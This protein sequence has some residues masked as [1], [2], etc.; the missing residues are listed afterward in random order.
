MPDVYVITNQL[1]HYWGKSKQWVD[2]KDRRAVVRARHQDEAVNT[3]VELSA[4][5]MDLR[6]QVVAV[7][8]SQRGEPE[9]T[10]SDIAIPQIEEPSG[11]NQEAHNEAP[12]HA[13]GNNNT[14]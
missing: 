1:G 6:G 2:G 7:P 10:I 11:A 5:D 8:L 12:S 3:L 4:K 9:V 13:V 14:P